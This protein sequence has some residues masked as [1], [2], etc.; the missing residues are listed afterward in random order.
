MTNYAYYR[1]STDE[2]DY[3]SQKVGVVRYCEYKNIKVDKEII[4][5]GV[6]GAKDYKKRK[7]GNLIKIA[8]KAI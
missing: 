3:Q 8:K 1:V 7:L 6:S 4:E 2:Q 5:E